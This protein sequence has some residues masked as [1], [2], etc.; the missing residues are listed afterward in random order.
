MLVNYIFL[1]IGFGISFLELLYGLSLYNLPIDIER[2]RGLSHISNAVAGL[3]F[4]SIVLGIITSEIFFTIPDLDSA[5]EF[6]NKVS[7]NLLGYQVGIAAVAARLQ[8]TMVLSPLVGL[9][10]AMTWLLNLTTQTLIF[11]FYSL[12]ILS[13]IIEWIFEFLVSLGIA[14]QTNDRTRSISGTMIASP[15]ILRIFLAWLPQVDF[16]KTLGSKEFPIKTPFQEV[17][18][19]VSSLWSGQSGLLADG[20]EFIKIIVFISFC[21]SLVVLVVYGLSKAFGGITHV[22]SSRI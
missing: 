20:L 17:W 15:I 12:Y 13:I 19:I 10:I 21:W 1:S 16:I 2:E 6:Y 3:I 8:A 18:E 7:R 22:I 11:I 5:K 9:W 4:M 14:L